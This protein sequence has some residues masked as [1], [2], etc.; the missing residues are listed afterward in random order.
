VV[1]VVQAGNL[2]KCSLKTNAEYSGGGVKSR[3]RPPG[4]MSGNGRVMK[5][6]S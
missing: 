5:I 6:M 2:F 4:Y 3:L 1:L